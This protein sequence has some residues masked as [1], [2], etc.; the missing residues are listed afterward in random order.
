MTPS[1]GNWTDRRAD[2]LVMR[3]S[4]MRVAR[5]AFPGPGCEPEIRQARQPATGNRP[6]YR[7]SYGRCAS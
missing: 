5:V 2:T 3:P 1:R 6:A 7:G 4:S